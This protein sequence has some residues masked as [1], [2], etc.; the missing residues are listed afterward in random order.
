MKIKQN[1]KF[2]NRLATIILLLPFF[3]MCSTSS[4]NN[5]ENKSN[6]ETIINKDTPINVV[7]IF[8]E[9]LG[10]KDF[11]TAYNLQQNSKWNDY[12]KFSSTK[13]FGGINATSI[14]EIRKENDESGKAVIYADAYYYDPVNGDNQFKQK[15]YLQKVD[16]QWKIVDFKIIEIVGS[17]KSKNKDF[18]KF[19]ALFE[20]SNLPYPSNFKGNATKI[21]DE[22]VKKYLS[23][24]EELDIDN[25]GGD[26]V[27]AVGKFK[28]DNDY[29]GLIFEFGEFGMGFNRYLFTFKKDGTYK[30]NLHIGYEFQNAGNY[31]NT[32][33]EIDTKYNLI[34]KNNSGYNSVDPDSE[35]NF[36]NEDEKNY[37]IKKGVITEK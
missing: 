7:T 5:T 1:I 11:E 12:E 6:E 30:S 8:I 13:S 16:K 31:Y 25:Y 10:K 15:F 19:I 17:N 24:N 37:T 2:Y 4:E 23:A 35:N 28:I 20:D 33:T 27:I 9:S 21:S 22:Y 34:Q 32:N 26:G 3:T 36:H 29:Y 18:E 14:N